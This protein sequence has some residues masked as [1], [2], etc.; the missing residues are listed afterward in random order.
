MF[1]IPFRIAGYIGRKK[2]NTTT[3]FAYAV[4]TLFCLSRYMPIRQIC[5][6]YSVTVSS[7]GLI[8]YVL[9]DRWTLFI[10]MLCWFYLIGDGPFYDC[11]IQ[12]VLLRSRRGQW[13]TG[14]ILFILL[15][16]ACFLFWAALLCILCTMPYVNFQPEWDNV[17]RS[18]TTVR[19]LSQRYHAYF[20]FTP[21]IYRNYTV[22]QAFGWSLS[23]HYLL[24]VFFG[25]FVTLFNSLSRQQA[26]VLIA[27]MFLIMD[28]SAYQWFASDF[29]YFYSPLSL[30]TLN[31][32]DL[33]STTYRPTPSYS[34]RFFAAVIILIITLFLFLMHRRS[35]VAIKHSAI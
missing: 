26:G 16:A 22:L 21:Y 3:F 5:A 8:A 24:L 1:S 13:A 10:F 18:L 2:C 6:D 25:V 17:I 7:L 33:H 29:Y 35:I 34:L 20:I 14:V 19:A 31:V 4:Y 30:V 15:S 27:G 28:M 12:Y 23:L 9:N 11:T 32:L